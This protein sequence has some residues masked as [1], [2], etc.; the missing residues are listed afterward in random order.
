MLLYHGS[1]LEIQKPK[2]MDSKRALDF[3]TGFYLTTDLEQAKRWAI[4]VTNRRHMGIPTVSIFEYNENNNLKILKFPSANKEWLKYISINRKMT[5]YN[6]DNDI[7]IGPVANDNTMPV[8]NLYLNG[9]Y[10][11]D[12]ALKRLLPQ[13][14]KNQVVFK[15]NKALEYLDFKEKIEYE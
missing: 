14:L 2:I 10:D 12:E 6:Y 7:I 15:T 5:N 1:N 9:D 11:E 13:K 3:G 4:L 8:I